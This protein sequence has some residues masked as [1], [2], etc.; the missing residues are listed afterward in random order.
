M[1]ET[2]SLRSRT[3][4]VD[5]FPTILSQTG[6]AGFLASGSPGSFPSRM[7]GKSMSFGNGTFRTPPSSL[8]QA[9]P[10]FTV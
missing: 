8:P 6:R 9:L 3:L 2:D 1:I 5:T 4:D 7:A 10:G